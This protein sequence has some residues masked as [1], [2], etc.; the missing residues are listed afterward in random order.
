MLWSVDAIRVSNLTK[1]YGRERGVNALSFGVAPGEVF[2]YVGPNGA[3]KTTTIRLLLDLI[4]PTSGTIEVFG[5]DV[6]TDASAIKR[7][8]GYIPGDLRLY[9]RLTGRELLAFFGHVRQLDTHAES[10]RLA[11]RFDLDLDRPIHTLSRG[12][13]QKIGLVQA[14]AHRP[15]LLVLD[16]P[17][18]GL[19][20][21]MQ[22]EFGALV[23]E[24]ASGGRTVFLS[25]H[26][27]SEVQRMADKVA[28]LREGELVLIDTVEGL[29]ARATARMDVTFAAVPSPDAFSRVQG[30]RELGRHG[31]MVS[32]ALEGTADALVKSLANHEV[33]TIDSHEA[34]LEDVF[35]ALYRGEPAHAG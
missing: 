16:E 6:T 2:G 10:D 14:F 22:Q 8:I 20:P 28:L 12:N 18:S 19:D 27:L 24:A 9:E 23:R 30:V 32:F 13:R 35:L 25:S 29:R 1:H 34:D 26:V 5:R 21:L 11:A 4:K 33:V 7:R 15:E 17:S 3:G 31:P